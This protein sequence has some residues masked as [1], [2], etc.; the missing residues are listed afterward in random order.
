MLGAVLRIEQARS[1]DAGV[2]RRGHS[3]EG[4]ELRGQARGQNADLHDTLGCSEPSEDRRPHAEIAR[5][6][7]A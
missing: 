7:T 1:G 2:P 3:E 6:T 4:T 5:I